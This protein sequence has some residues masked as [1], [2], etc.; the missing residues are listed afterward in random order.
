MEEKKIVVHMV[1]GTIHK[2]IT[3]DFGPDRTDFHLLPAE[4]GGVPVRIRVGE[5]KALFYVKDWLGNRD[6][7]ARRSF[8]KIREQGRKA[9]LTFEDGETMWGTVGHGEESEQGFFFY[10]VDEQDNN[11]RIFVVRDSLKEIRWVP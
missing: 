1:G 6:F 5:M 3:L 8:E 2:G 4:G 10:P 7:V 9:I 11:E